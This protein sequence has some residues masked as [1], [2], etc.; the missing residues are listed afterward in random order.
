MKKR[1][2]A[3]ITILLLV[4]SLSLST[5]AANGFNKAVFDNAADV[6]VTRD[7]MDGTLTAMTTSLIGE[8]GIIAPEG[9]D[10]CIQ[11]Y[12]GVGITDSVN[13]LSIVFKDYS[14]DAANINGII[15]KIGNKRYSFSGINV[16]WDVLRGSNTYYTG[17][18]TTIEIT[19]KSIPMM[20]ELIEHRDEEIRV[21]LQGTNRN[22]DFV[23]TDDMKNSIIN[24]YNLYVAGGG[25]NAASMQII[26][27]VTKIDVTV[28]QD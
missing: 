13:L 23:L 26:D 5:F 25:T 12:A 22:V 21:R 9:R 16:S 8:K 15:I 14:H 18:S 19:S 2:V 4:A 28:G 7:D 10:E 3:L 17:E 24:L 6:T 1:L 11:V 20:T 27:K